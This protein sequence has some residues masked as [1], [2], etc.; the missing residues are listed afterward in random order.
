MDIGAETPEEIAMSII[1][2]IKAVCA[3]R[4]GGFLRDR[5]APIHDEKGRAVSAVWFS[6]EAIATAQ[7]SESVAVH[8]SS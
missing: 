2:E 4:D 7:V 3:K 5:T 8:Q 6:A 1:A